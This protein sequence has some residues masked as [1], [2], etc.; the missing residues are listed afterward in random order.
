MRGV[1]RKIGTDDGAGS[2][3]GVTAGFMDKHGREGRA[4]MRAAVSLL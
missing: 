2:G 1:R 3:A 4:R